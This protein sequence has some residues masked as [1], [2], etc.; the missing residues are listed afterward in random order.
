MVMNDSFRRA[1]HIVQTTP[2]IHRQ[3]DKLLRYNDLMVELLRLREFVHPPDVCHF[4]VTTIDPQRALGMHRHDF[5]EIFWIDAGSGWH[6]INGHQRVARP[7]SIT[8]VRAD[9]E[10]TFTAD[11][12]LRLVNVAFAPVAWRRLQRRYFPERADLFAEGTIDQRELSLRAEQWR[13]LQLISD[14]LFDGGRGRATL[15][16]FLLNLVHMAHRSLPA[17]GPA[18]PGWLVDA[19]RQ[20]REP[21]HLRRGTA[22]FAQLAGKTPEHVARVSR[23]Y[24]GKSPTDLVNEARVAHAAWQLTSTRASIMDICLDCGLENLGHFY[25][26]FKS[27]IGMSPRQ[28]RLQQARILGSSS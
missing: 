1:D 14:E 20:I 7:G 26:L 23:R 28:Y 11:Q 15:D 21:Q 9:D 18:L 5:V 27:H 6:W 3:S 12:S 24:L 19:C 4:A 22:G 8:F 17:P 13:Q 16:R 2:Q 25:Q 10:H